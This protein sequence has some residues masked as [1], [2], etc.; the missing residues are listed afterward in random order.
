MLDLVDVTHPARA[1]AGE[2]A[3]LAV[4]RLVGV[5]AEEIG[6]RLAAVGTGFEDAIDL[7]VATDAVER[8]VATMITPQRV[9]N[10]T[11]EE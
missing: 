10:R 9:T 1:E 11:T 2:D 7:R 8:H 6:H 5:L 4:D 3:V